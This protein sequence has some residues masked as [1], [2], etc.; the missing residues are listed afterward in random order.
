M[1]K[2]KNI[3]KKGMILAAVSTMVV[4]MAPAI[5][6]YAYGE[7]DSKTG[8]AKFNAATTESTDYQSWL[9]GTWQGGTQDFANTNKIALTPG[10]TA[11]DLGFA[12][13][14]NTK[15]TPAVMVWKDGSKAGA[16]IVKGTA[17]DISAEN[18]QGEVYAASNKVSINGFFEPD[19]K[20]VYQYTDNY[21]DNGDTVWS[22][23][24]TYTT[25]AT[26]TFSVILTGDPQIGASGSK[27]DKDAND[28]SIAQD[29][30]NWNKT[31]QQALKTCPDASFLLSAGDQINQSGATKDNDKKTR[32]S[33]YAG[34]LYPSV[35]RSL[36]I[37]A[38]IG[39]HD[40]DGSDYTAHFNNPNSEDNL[41]STGAGCDFY[42]NNGNVLFISLNSNNRN[43]T[44]HREFMKKAI[45]SNP[46][47]A[48]RVVVFHS[49]IYGSGQP[50]ADTDA[51]TNRIIFAPLMDEFDI[52]VCLTGHDHT[53]SRSYQVQDGNVID[54]DLSKGSVNNPE[55]T[56]YIT[57]GSGSGSKYYNLLNYTPYYIAERT[58]AC[59]PSF[60]TI[61]FSSGAMTIK[62]YDYNGNKYAYAASFGEDDIP[63]D[64]LKR[65]KE[66]VSRFAAVSVREQAAWQVLNKEKIESQVVIDPVLLLE[67]GEWKKTVINS[68]AHK[69]KY[70]L[71]YCVEKSKRVFDYARR[72]SDRT[73]LK[74]YYL[75]QN[76][77]FK[78]KDF[79]YKRGVSP[80][81]FLNYIQDAEYIVTNSFHGTA[82]SIIFEKKFAVDTIWHGEKNIRIS[83]L[84][85]MFELNDR[86]MNSLNE[87][88]GKEI[89]YTSVKVVLVE[90]RKLAQQFLDKCFLE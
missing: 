36:P 51:T 22:A 46:D 9:T 30:Y 13:Y 28:M 73:G 27:S 26:D 32:E 19:T 75:N 88:I 84:L 11:K 58:N 29:A 10:S 8:Q 80:I 59:L 74:I 65:I 90:N 60:S 37:A 47:A 31:M 72:L 68:Q 62:T 24:Y 70:I 18:W 53:Y 57:T 44:E 81:E 79:I 6:A 82:F 89:D 35:F 52:D 54:Y 38:T 78:E 33:E 77:F 43:Q 42:F 3:L 15:G 85:S 34:Y 63:E 25:H 1:R 86:D 39:N 7:A 5:P 64:A 69:E 45:A 76:M 14:S 21:S 17:T 61:D 49:D 40:K 83:N 16:Q 56:L 12:W 50:H 48:W 71:V 4:T 67:E 41:G 66:D 87:N 2:N 20:Y 23:E 55:G